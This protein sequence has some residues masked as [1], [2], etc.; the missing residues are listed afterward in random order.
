MYI[1]ARAREDTAGVRM[2]GALSARTILTRSH[3]CAGVSVRLCFSWPRF[4]SVVTLRV[5]FSWRTLRFAPRLI[6]T[7][8][9]W[10]SACS[11]NKMLVFREIL[12]N[13]LQNGKFRRFPKN[14][15]SAR[16]SHTRHSRAQHDV[17]VYKHACASMHTDT[18]RV[19][20]WTKP[21]DLTWNCC[22]RRVSPA[23]FRDFT[24]NSQKIV[25]KVSKFQAFDKMAGFCQNYRKICCQ[26]S[27]FRDF[28]GKNMKN[29]VEV[30][31]NRW[32]LG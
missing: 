18:R 17:H 4:A 14:P 27:K 21:K 1:R 5:H 23:F 9:A 7:L 12:K 24:K 6:L 31:T 29:V 19:R 10:P 28:F 32:F 20:V 26:F 30:H 2:R 16:L 11:K 8:R 22:F 13:L 3:V 25:R 15:P